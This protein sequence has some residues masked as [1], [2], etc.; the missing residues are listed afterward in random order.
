MREKRSR[1]QLHHGYLES[2]RV[3]S[4]F[5]FQPDHLGFQSF[6]I[7]N[8]WP[9]KHQECEHYPLPQVATTCK[10]KTVSTTRF[11]MPTLFL[12]SWTG[13]TRRIQHLTFIHA[14]LA[15]EL[16]TRICMSHFGIVVQFTRSRF[17]RSRGGRTDRRPRARMDRW[18]KWWGYL[19]RLLWKLEKWLWLDKFISFPVARAG[20]KNYARNGIGLN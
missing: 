19:M 2:H 7:C 10:I 18:F 13:P 1:F 12:W 14:S 8:V 11:C 4:L 20:V 15:G 6:H 16:M 5:Q 3:E 17:R 9:K